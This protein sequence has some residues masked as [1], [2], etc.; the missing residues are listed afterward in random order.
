M[1][2]R[3]ATSKDVSQIL[4]FIQKKA[5]FDQAM[6]AFSGVVQVSEEKIASTIAWVIT[7]F[8]GRRSYPIR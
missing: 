1:L 8:V 2:V 7:Q 5:A 3:P 4:S 6:G